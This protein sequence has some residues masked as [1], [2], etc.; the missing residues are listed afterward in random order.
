[1]LLCEGEW[2]DAHRPWAVL[3]SETACVSFAA[4]SQTLLPEKGRAP[5]SGSGE[6]A[7]K[8]LIFTSAWAACW[9]E[10]TG[11][12]QENAWCRCSLAALPFGGSF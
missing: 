10:S 4:A 11:E 2:A 12:R 3:P 6:A 9:L 8:S 5:Q 7:E 1:V